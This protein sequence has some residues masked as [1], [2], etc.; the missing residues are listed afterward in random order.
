MAYVMWIF[1]P[2]MFVLAISLAPTVVTKR[3]CPKACRTYISTEIEGKLSR[4]LRVSTNVLV[5]SSLMALILQRNDFILIRAS[6][7]CVC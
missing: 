7:H 5:S 6:F 2:F 4:A 3:Q 1:L